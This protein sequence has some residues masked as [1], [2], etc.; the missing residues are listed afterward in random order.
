M[1]LAPR[2]HPC[3]RTFDP[4]TGAYPSRHVQGARLVLWNANEWIEYPL[5]RSP[6]EQ[7]HNPASHLLSSLRSTHKGRAYV[8][9][10]V[11]YE[12]LTL[13]EARQ[14]SRH[15]PSRSEPLR[16]SLPSTSGVQPSQRLSRPHESTYTSLPIGHAR[17]IRFWA[18]VRACQAAIGPPGGC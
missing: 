11:P 4:P 3:V 16:C 13:R 18:W 2:V 12:G 7:K 1:R 9:L 6:K 17:K 10:D 14:G 5:G 15:A 8:M